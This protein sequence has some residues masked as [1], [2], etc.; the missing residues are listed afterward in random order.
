M[1][2]R[3]PRPT[4]HRLRTRAEQIADDL[5]A[6]SSKDAT[7]RRLPSRDSAAKLQPAPRPPTP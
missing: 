7:V 6:Q 3:M 1:T 4:Q 2:D 5:A